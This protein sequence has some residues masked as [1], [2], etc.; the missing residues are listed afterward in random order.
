M[1][2]Q[3]M[4]VKIREA[5]IQMKPS[6]KPA[7]PATSHNREATPNIQALQS[8]ATTGIEPV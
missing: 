4:A 5:T 7:A 3:L 2:R 6:E 8:K 1:P